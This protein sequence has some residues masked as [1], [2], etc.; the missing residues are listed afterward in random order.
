V[1]EAV[2]DYTCSDF[3]YRITL[4][5]APDGRLRGEAARL[6]NA[7]RSYFRSLALDLD[8]SVD[9]DEGLFSGL[10]VENGHEHTWEGKLERA[11]G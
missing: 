2:G 6:E 7:G 3:R 9:G 10:L 4:N 1:T 8:I 5:R 11:A